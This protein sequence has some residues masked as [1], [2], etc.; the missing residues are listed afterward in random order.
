MLKAG[1]RKKRRKGKET[2][3][4]VGEKGNVGVRKRQGKWRKHEGWG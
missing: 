2:R 4:D 3:R 1:G